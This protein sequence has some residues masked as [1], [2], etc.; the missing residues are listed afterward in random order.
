MT[1]SYVPRTLVADNNKLLMDVLHP[2]LHHQNHRI[3]FKP[4]NKILHASLLE[5]ILH[6]AFLAQLKLM[7]DF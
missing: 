6:G 1:Q 3:S 4:K 2:K 7:V 5:A